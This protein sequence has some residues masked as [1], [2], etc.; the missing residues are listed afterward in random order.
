VRRLLP[1][2][3]A[4]QLA[5]LL[6]AGLL[7]AHLV[8]LLVFSGERGRALDRAAELGLVER[9]AALVEVIDVA[10]PEVAERLA[11][12]LS[13]RRV[14]LALAAESAIA[15][16]PM[17]R[18]EQALADQLAEALALGERQARVRLGEAGRRGPD[19][20]P[21]RR[22]RETTIAVSILLHDGGWLNAGATIRRPPVG[23]SW[24]WLLTLAASAAAILAVVALLVR[25]ITA[26]MRALAAAAEKIG[27]G[28]AAAP[29]PPRGPAEVRATVEAFNA[30]QA[31]LARF[32]GDRTRMIA[33]IGHDLRTPITSLRLRAEFVEDEEL[34]ADIV[35]MLDEMQA[36]VDATLAFARDDAAGEETRTVDLAALVEGIVDDQTALGRAVSYEGPERLP[37]RCRPVSLKRAISNL[38]ENAIRYA[39]SAHVV[40]RQAAGEVLVEVEDKG[41][42]V[43]EEALESLFE[44]FVRLEGSRSRQTGGVGLGLSIARSIARAH[45]GELTLANRAEGGLRATLSLP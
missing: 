12:A 33:A 31:R 3:L 28:E 24:P 17:S 16:G 15:D 34:R 22:G 7:A 43:P 2:S 19:G 39:G 5:T 32:V 13:S 4:G 44:P 30:M 26:P 9:L 27:R 35:R 29:I 41:A 6:I 20:R 21:R 23:W 42:G 40:L 11:G 38:V 8:G 14:H 18:A 37:W 36:M 10:S 1:S 25:R 45:G